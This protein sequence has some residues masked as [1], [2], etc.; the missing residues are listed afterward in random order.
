MR[1]TEVESTTVIESELHKLGVN[2]PLMA[3]KENGV[4]IAK[5]LDTLCVIEDYLKNYLGYDL[6]NVLGD[7]E[8]RE[9]QKMQ[10]T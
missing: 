3:Y 5:G 9:Y 1:E 7:Y 2:Y 6:T 8:W 4:V 10:T